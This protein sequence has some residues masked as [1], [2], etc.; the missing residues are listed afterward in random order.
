MIKIR[1]RPIYGKL[2]IDKQ[3][4]ELS[5]FSNTIDISQIAKVSLMEEMTFS[6]SAI[7]F[8][9]MNLKIN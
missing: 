7:L 4:Q 5:S 6:L 9:V 3:T 8:N 2:L 1:I